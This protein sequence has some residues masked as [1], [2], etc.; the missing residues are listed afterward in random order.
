MFPEL[1]DTRKPSRA[2]AESQDWLPESFVV[3]EDSKGREEEK[4]VVFFIDQKKFETTESSLTVHA[5]LTEYAAED[6]SQTVLVL[7]KGNTLDRLED[8]NASVKLENGIRFV[9]FHTGPTPVS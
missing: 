8:L 9:V 7:K 3:K 4:K 5:L 6:A 1:F 2:T